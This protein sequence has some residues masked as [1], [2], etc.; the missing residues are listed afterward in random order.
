M[1]ELE[2]Y[3]SFVSLWVIVASSLLLIISVARRLSMRH[4][5]L[6]TSMY[7]LEKGKVHYFKY[8]HGLFFKRHFQI[9]AEDRE[10][11]NYVVK[12]VT[13]Y[14]FHKNIVINVV[15]NGLTLYTVELK[16]VSDM[17]EFNLND[18]EID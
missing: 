2:K 3:V 12:E 1:L 5:V 9:V 18:E 10:D 11:T 14:S 6:T 15:R 8:V 16:N 7:V 13:F 4:R 17:D